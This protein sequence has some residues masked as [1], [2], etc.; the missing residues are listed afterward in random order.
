[1]ELRHFRYFVAVAE[2]LHFGEAA[3]RLDIAQPALSQQIRRLEEELRTPLL[4]RTRRHVE[5]T[6]AGRIFLEEARATLAQAE[7]A[8]RMAQR[9]SRGE[10]GQLKVGFVKWADVSGIP[11]AIRTFGLRYP[12]V[13]L[14]LHSLS[15][16]EQTE[17]LRAGRINVG[18]TRPLDCPDL[19]SEPLFWEPLIVVFPRRHPFA[20]YPRVP[21]RMLSSQP[22]ISFSQRQAPCFTALVA[23]ACRQAGIALKIRHEVDHPQ[24]LMALVEAGIGVSLVPASFASVKRPGIQHRGMRPV[25]PTLETILAW[26]RDDR[27]RLLQE[28]IRIVEEVIAP[29]SR[30][31]GKSGA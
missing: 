23:D 4:R 16:P 9:A 5:L 1:M 24:T 3:L 13:E 10:I 12:E 26:R 7:R 14:E 20:G 19:A 11:K 28:F 27:S 15:A 8:V 18:F 29:R 21:W 30:P 17:A 25:G 22:Y 2:Q 6:D 31:G